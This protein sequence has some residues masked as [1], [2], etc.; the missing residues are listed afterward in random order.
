MKFP[1]Q[2]TWKSKKYRDWIKTQACV[3]C[4]RPADDPHHIIGK[5][6]GGAGMK[7]PDCCAMPMCRQCHSKVH[8]SS[9]F[10]DMQEKWTLQTIH[11]ALNEGILKCSR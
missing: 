11:R 7:A 6:W 5:G 2:K 4:H 3:M 8:S 9:D 1:K 10:W